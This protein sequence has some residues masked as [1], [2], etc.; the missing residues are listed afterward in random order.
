MLYVGSGLGKRRDRPEYTR[1]LDH[2]ISVQLASMFALQH[3]QSTFLLPLPI[4]ISISISIFLFFFYTSA[5]RYTRELFYILI[6]F[7]PDL[8]RQRVLLHPCKQFLHFPGWVS[9]PVVGFAIGRYRLNVM[10]LRF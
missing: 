7:N 1:S 10:N 5:R 2:S 3:V 6:S 9:S 8:H 4:S